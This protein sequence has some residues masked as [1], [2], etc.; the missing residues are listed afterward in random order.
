MN[1][2]NNEMVKR[3][4]QHV[5]RQ[6]TSEEQTH[7][8]EARRLTD[9]EAPEIRRKAKQLKAKSDVA[10]AT[11]QDALRLLRAERVRQGLSLA[12]IQ[13]RTGIERPNLSRLENE[14]SSNP[15]VATLTRYAEALGK[16]LVIV[17]ADR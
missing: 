7:V 4:A 6:L 10:R 13:D 11:L 16:R 14:D 9:A 1:Q 17:L 2:R 12:D 3:Q 8:D 5:R 15:T